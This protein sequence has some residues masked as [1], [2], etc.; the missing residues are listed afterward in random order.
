LDWVRG[1]LGLGLILGQSLIQSLG[2]RLRL[3]LR[4]GVLGRDDGLTFV[5]PQDRVRGWGG[6]GI[7]WEAEDAYSTVW[8]WVCLRRWVWLWTG[9][10]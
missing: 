1:M 5:L 10:G 6:R 7:R 2:L 9:N 4:L 8:I 3:R